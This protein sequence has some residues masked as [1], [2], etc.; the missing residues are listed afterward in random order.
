MY[1]LGGRSFLCWAW[2]GLFGLLSALKNYAQTDNPVSK[3]NTKRHVSKSMYCS[4]TIIRGEP[5]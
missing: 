3:C 1:R 2:I 5:L 4:T